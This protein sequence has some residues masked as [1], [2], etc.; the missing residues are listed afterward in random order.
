ME[1]SHQVI[2]TLNIY[3][4]S[5][6]KISTSENLNIG[7]TSGNPDTHHLQH[8]KGGVSLF[9]PLCKEILYYLILVKTERLS[10][11]VVYPYYPLYKTKPCIT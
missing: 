11:R 10:R 1:A 5:T 3:R 9:S 8:L 6:Y 7:V 4:Y 2:L